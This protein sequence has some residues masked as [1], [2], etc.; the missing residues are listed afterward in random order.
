MLTFESLN[1][2]TID[3]ITALAASSDLARYSW[4]GR[5]RAPIGYVKGMAVVYGLCLQKL[6]ARDSA[7]LAMVRVV[8]GQHDV[9]DHY[10]SQLRAIGL[11]TD[12][13]TE[14]D[15][16]RALF[17]IL[18]GLGMRESSGRYCEGRDQSASNMSAET[19]EAGLFQM[20]WDGRRASTEI[21]RLVETYSAASARGGFVDIFRE[22]VRPKEGDLS[23]Y[24]EGPGEKFQE[25]CKSCPSFA[26]EA[27][28]IGLRTLYTHWGPIVRQEAQVR[29]EA[30]K[31]FRQ[32][33]DIV[34]VQST[35]S[36][37]KP[38]PQSSGWAA[39]WAALLAWWRGSSDQ[40]TPDRPAEPAPT[41]LAGRIV[42]AMR[43]R[44]FKVDDVPGNP[45]VV[46]VEGMGPD[47]TK[48]DNT[49]N[50]FNDA[51]FVIMFGQDGRPK[52]AGAWE[53]T[54]EPGRYWTEN[55]MNSKGAARIKFGQ[56][57]AW[58]VGMHH[59]HEALVQTG[60][61]VTVCRDLNEDYKREGDK[62][63]TGQFGIN[64]HWGYDFPKNDLGQSSAGCLV[65][66]MKTGHQQ[67]MALMKSDPRYKANSRFVFTAAVL[68]ASEV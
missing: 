33:Q 63:D 61:N 36:V 56:Y 60:G 5:G 18:T 58:Q 1:Q 37:G 50:Q 27:A 9:F 40:P 13:G 43:K 62:E 45:N 32:V 44:G 47:G 30:D 29:P 65:G 46:Y 41:D 52:I 4:G 2:Q 19:A 55:P 51:R 57:T 3:K 31:L 68:P 7:A 22:G 8:D 11:V 67:F 14:V 39:M 15:R 24:G 21:P 28:A 34:G 25:L 54:T 10:E 42:A 16:L 49:P 35:G 20:S 6:R 53:A 48:N 59:T 12:G 26:V 17:V 38:A 64:Q 66:R 23:N